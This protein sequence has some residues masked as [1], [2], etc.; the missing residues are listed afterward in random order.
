MSAPNTHISK[1]NQMNIIPLVAERTDRFIDRELNANTSR[2]SG[3]ALLLALSLMAFVLLLLLSITTLVQVEVQ[4]ASISKTKEQ[5]QANALLAIYEGLGELQRT[6]GNDQ[7]STALADLFVSNQSNSLAVVSPYWLGVWNTRLAWEGDASKSF[8]AN[9]ADWD[10]LS[11]QQKIS[12]ARG[13]LVSGKNL[14]ATKNPLPTDPVDPSAALNGVRAYA[15]MATIPQSRALPALARQDAVYAPKEFIQGA[16]DQVTGSYAWWVA[17]EGMK[18]KVNVVDPLWGE[19]DEELRER[20]ATL[21]PRPAAE[22]LI[23]SAAYDPD[24]YSKIMGIGTFASFDTLT[25]PLAADET[26]SQ[27]HF[28]DFT[29][30][31]RGVLSNSRQGGLRK[32]L[33]LAFDIEDAFGR[34]VDGMPAFDMTLLDS[35]FHTTATSTSSRL[36][37]K[38]NYLF[39]L[40][41]VIYDPAGVTYRNF[42]KDF[43][44][45]S[46][47]DPIAGPAWNLLAYY[48][49]LYQLT[50][51]GDTIPVQRVF[52]EEPDPLVWKRGGVYIADNSDGDLVPQHSSYGVK[53][54]KFSLYRAMSKHTDIMNRFA[55]GK[56]QRFNLTDEPTNYGITPILSE[57]LI[58]V[59]VEYTMAGEVK[60]YYTPVLELTNPYDA[61]LTFP[62]TMQMEVMIS[63]LNALLD[64][65]L[66]SSILPALAANRWSDAQTSIDGT[67]LA[68]FTNLF[69]SLPSTILSGGY[70]IDAGHSGNPSSLDSSGN[71]G[72]SDARFRRRARMLSVVRDADLNRTVEGIDYRRMVSDSLGKLIFR[73]HSADLGSFTPGQSKMFT[74]QNPNGWAWFMQE[75]SNTSIAQEID[76]RAYTLRKD[77]ANAKARPLPQYMDDSDGI[78]PSHPSVYDQLEV[79]VLAAGGYEFD[80]PNSPSQYA[81]HNYGANL[82]AR[83]LSDVTGSTYGYDTQNFHIPMHAVT[84]FKGDPLATQAQQISLTRGDRLRLLTARIRQRSADEISVSLSE[85]AFLGTTTPRASLVSMDGGMTPGPGAMPTMPL[86][87]D[88]FPTS[89]PNTNS[90]GS[91]G[92]TKVGY[93]NTPLFHVPRFRPQSL[94]DYRHVNFSTYSHEPA[95]P[96]GNSLK[97]GFGWSDRSKTWLSWTEQGVVQGAS[98]VAVSFGSEII[99]TQT[100]PESSNLLIDNGYHLNAGLWDSYFLSTLTVSEVAAFESGVGGANLKQLPNHRIKPK[101]G[102]TELDAGAL[103]DFRRSAGELLYEGSFNVNS[104]SVKAWAALLRSMQDIYPSAG[105]SAV[106]DVF[107]RHP[108]IPLDKDAWSGATAL[109]PDQIYNAGDHGYEDAPVSLAGHIVKQVKERGPFMSLAHF[110]NRSLVDDE[111][112]DAGALHAAIQDSGINGDRNPFAPGSLSQADLLGALGAS[113]SARSDTFLIRAKGECL[114][115][116]SRDVQGQAWCEA[117]VQRMPDYIDGLQ[118]PDESPN[119]A[120]N[121]ALGRR[122]QIVS[123]R[124]LDESEI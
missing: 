123:F 111:R 78:W 23:Q 22:M 37:L 83:I 13:W 45:T 85:D 84:D 20:R 17:D 53:Q 92:D 106:S 87:L 68:D 114:D 14:S 55:V 104:T 12:V 41:D 25:P 90:F 28:H 36:D 50:Q 64:F 4:S 5:A 33:S 119:T 69:P 113:L 3:F 26:L 115:P 21:A 32:D 58:D 19:S 6:T 76:L 74:L 47:T 59:E 40:E 29:V 1:R 66:T 2:R 11:R 101:A 10:Q 51:G 15:R 60:L 35:F 75:S 65:K 88:I 94:A 97:P 48:H 63:K 34:D 18:A 73:I 71:T 95:M 44:D 79:E 102:S 124:W 7:V 38:D 80:K 49:N 30:S 122:Y 61:S 99:S 31:S 120:E 112:G 9:Q 93:S 117:V 62:H 72:V 103:A 116:A 86:E 107:L 56:V 91:W 46:G 27:E 43:Y 70:R 121:V 118:L 8:Y 16:G 57:V 24:L 100:Q 54:E 105:G 110:V 98:S 89:P 52:N 77:P 82:R 96:F 39:F 108:Q 81:V 109:D 67:T 42:Y